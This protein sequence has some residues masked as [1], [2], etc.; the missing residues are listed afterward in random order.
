MTVS[1]AASLLEL[2]LGLQLGATGSAGRNRCTIEGLTCRPREDGAFEIGIERLE[3]MALRIASG[4][5]GLEV[6]RIDVQGLAAQVRADG[7]TARMVSLQAREAA[8]SGLK[9]HGPVALPPQVRKLREAMQAPAASAPAAGV[10]A[11]QA[12]D[13]AWRLDPLA[14]AEGTVRS[15]ITDAHLLFDADVTVPIR[16]GGIDFNDA[17]VEHVGP[18]SRMGVSKMGLYVDAPDG[19]SYLYQF[20]AAPVAGVTFERRGALLGPW[21]SE[22]GSLRLQEFAESMLRQGRRGPGQG[23]TEQARLL[24]GRTA[25]SGELRLGDGLVAMPGLQVFVEA[26]EGGGHVVALHAESVGRGLT[27]EIA[28]LTA[29]DAVADWG[30][31]ALGAARLKAALSL[32]LRVDDSQMRFELALA[33]GRAEGLRLEA[34]PAASAPALPTP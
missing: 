33:D 19:R 23:L 15:R 2:A 27:A 9:L 22:R 11:G 31:F 5:H 8:F 26:N 10:A 12:R 24:L 3:A 29:R 13:D 14:A 30:G 1:L 17:T 4:A 7:G 20:A 16:A 18:D 6:E 21:I 32:Q 28:S 34:A 25:L